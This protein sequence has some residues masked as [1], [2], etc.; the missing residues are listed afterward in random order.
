MSMGK[1]GS[2]PSTSGRSPRS[3]AS[4]S[5]TASLTLTAVNWVLRSAAFWPLACMAT[6][7]PGAMIR[8]QGILRTPAYSV[9]ALCAL[10][11]VISI[12]TRVAT[13]LQRQTRRP[14]AYSPANVAPPLMGS[15]RLQ[16]KP[17]S[18]LTSTSSKPLAQRA[19]NLF[20]LSRLGMAGSVRS[21]YSC[22]ACVA[23]C[24]T[25]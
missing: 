3:A 12:N 15:T 11:R 7:A 17:I 14:S 10:A 24:T 25:R 19:R 1:S 4:L 13:R 16:C 2:A 9:S 22:V 23:S 20:S 5:Q 18:S 8:S 21:R 6:V